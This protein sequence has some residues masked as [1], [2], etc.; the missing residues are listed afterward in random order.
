MLSFTS[1]LFRVVLLL[2]LGPAYGQ[3]Y[4]KGLDA[5]NS[6]DYATAL[7]EWRALAEQ[8]QAIA[9]EHRS[10]RGSPISHLNLATHNAA[11]AR[12]RKTP[13]VGCPARHEASEP[14]RMLTQ[15]LPRNSTS[16]LLEARFP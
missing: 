10:L 1:T 9:R 11:I 13:L 5:Y 16:V 4:Q 8:G 14:P 15:C 6:G 12:A 7:R 3:D 2:A